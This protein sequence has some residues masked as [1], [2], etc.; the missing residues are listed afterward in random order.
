MQGLKF[1]TRTSDRR[2]WN[3]ASYHSPHSLTWSWILSLSLPRPGEGRWFHFYRT[4]NNTGLHWLLQIA[5]IALRW[6]TQRPMFYRDM[7]YRLR[8]KKDEAL[9]EDRPLPHA[10][11]SLSVIDGGQSLH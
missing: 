9:G 7:Y 4:R 2:C 8:D 1:F 11:P 5:R 6:Q 3:L 10:L